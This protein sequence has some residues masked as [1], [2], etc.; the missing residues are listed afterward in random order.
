MLR[1][2]RDSVNHLEDKD[3]EHYKIILDPNEVRIDS[4]ET[5]RESYTKNS[6]QDPDLVTKS[7]VD[8]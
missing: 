5:R 8:F 7:D 1:M 3:I 2:L 4:T 6:S